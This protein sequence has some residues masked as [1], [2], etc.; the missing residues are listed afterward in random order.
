MREGERARV[1]REALH[2]FSYSLSGETQSFVSAVLLIPRSQSL[3]PAY[4]FGEVSSMFYCLEGR[5]FFAPPCGFAGN[6]FQREHKPFA[7]QR[8]RYWLMRTLSPAPDS[9]GKEKRPGI[10]GNA[11]LFPDLIQGLPRRS[12]D[13]AL[14][15]FRRK[16]GRKK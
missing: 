5:P 8:P 6:H 3:G 15:R 9:A 14:L 10:G 7:Y 2:P 13:D 4:K 1:T 16:A 12:L 11:F